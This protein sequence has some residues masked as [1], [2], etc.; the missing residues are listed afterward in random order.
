MKFKQLESIKKMFED[1]GPNGL[2]TELINVI[3]GGI[4]AIYIFGAMHTILRLMQSTDITN[5]GIGMLLAFT[6][7]IAGAG[8]LNIVFKSQGISGGITALFLIFLLTDNMFFYWLA[9]TLFGLFA[10]LVLIFL[11]TRNKQV[12]RKKR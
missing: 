12:K 7:L 11:V 1:I 5:A 3:F 6:L 8:L 10:T 4:L 9:L 2:K